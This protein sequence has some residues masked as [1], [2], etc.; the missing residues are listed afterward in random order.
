MSRLW[1]RWYRSRREFDI[2]LGLDRGINLL[3]DDSLINNLHVMSLTTTRDFLISSQMLRTQE[4]W[5]SSGKIFGKRTKILKYS[6]VNDQTEIKGKFFIGNQLVREGGN[7]NMKKIPASWGENLLHLSQR[8]LARGLKWSKFSLR[9]AGIFW[10][11]RFL[12]RSP[13]DSLYISQINTILNISENCPVV[14][15]LSSCPRV[16]IMNLKNRPLVTPYHPL[17][18]CSAEFWLVT[19]QELIR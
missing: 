8:A 1:R 2:L 14:K 15:Y 10:I 18:T 16:K 3:R 13:V 17:A 5:S 19:W 4:F 11:L 12:P 9:L 6:H 7:Q